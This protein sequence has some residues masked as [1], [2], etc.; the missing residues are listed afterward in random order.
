MFLACLYLRWSTQ[1][2][3]L[4]YHYNL[5]EILDSFDYKHVI[6]LSKRKID[7]AI[8]HSLISEEDTPF[9]PS[10]THPGHYF[11]TPPYLGRAPLGAI[12]AVVEFITEITVEK[13]EYKKR[14]TKELPPISFRISGSQNKRWMTLTAIL[15]IP[16]YV[17]KQY[18]RKER[19]VDI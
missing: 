3:S 4:G 7:G 6:Y 5:V 14:K 16:V 11:S 13:H 15:W 1:T 10:P 12:R 8:S 18:W 19:T 17:R 9:L 2:H